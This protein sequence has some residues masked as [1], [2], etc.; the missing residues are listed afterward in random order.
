MPYV[1]SDR[2]MHGRGR[3]AGDKIPDLVFFDDSLILGDE[4]GTTLTIVEFKKPSRDDYTFGNVKS[5]PVMQVVETLEKA[6]AARGIQKTDGSHIS[7]T[8]V[9]RKFA[10]IVA[11]ITPSLVKVL[12]THDFRNDWNPK[13]YIR[14]RDNEQIFIQ[15]LGYET[16]VDL[17][18]KRNQA[19][20]SVLL[21][22]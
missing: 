10:F 13:L 11:D 7:F 1:S 18:K 4:D 14:Y 22:N 20:F 8:G 15:V 2:A 6:T 19:F 9:V 5:D 12:R 3:K 17:A 21:G 16:L